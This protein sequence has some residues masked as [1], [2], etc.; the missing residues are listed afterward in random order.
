MHETI[1][2]LEEGNFPHPHFFTCNG[3]LI[4]LTGMDLN[5]DRRKL[6]RIRWKPPEVEAKMGKALADTGEV[7]GRRTEIGAFIPGRCAVNP[8]F[9]LRYVGGDPLHQEGP[10]GVPSLVYEADNSEAPTEKI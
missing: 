3:Y 4:L 1:V 6:D 8:E 9:H 5:G 7:R 10:G 2:I